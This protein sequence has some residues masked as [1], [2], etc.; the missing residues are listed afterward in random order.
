MMHTAPFSIDID[1]VCSSDLLGDAAEEQP[2]FCNASYDDETCAMCLRQWLQA[3]DKRACVCVCS[4]RDG[5]TSLWVSSVRGPA[6]RYGAFS[7]LAKPYHLACVF[8]AR[9]AALALFLCSQRR[10][11]VCSW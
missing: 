11:R 10:L 7:Q 6:A 5:L 1:C 8:A 3:A 4:G 2:Y 9:A